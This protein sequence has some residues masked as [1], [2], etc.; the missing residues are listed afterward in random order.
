MEETNIQQNFK[1]LQDSH[2]SMENWIILNNLRP[3][4]NSSSKKSA[5]D[6]IGNSSRLDF[7]SMY[8]Q[9]GK[10]NHSGKLIKL[11][12]NESPPYLTLTTSKT[13]EH[14]MESG[15]EAELLKTVR[16][17]LGFRY[18]IL[19]P[20]DGEW[21]R[22]LP[23]GSWTGLVGMLNRKEADI[24]AG[25]IT[26]TY[27]RHKACGFSIPYDIQKSV[28][29]S[30]VPG[31]K[32]KTYAVLT[33]FTAEVWVLFIILLLIFLCLLYG[34]Q[35]AYHH[36]YQRKTY[37]FGKLFL[38]LLGTICSEG[39]WL[40]PVVQGPTSVLL[41]CLWLLFVLVMQAAYSSTLMS[42]LSFPAYDPP[43]DTLNDLAKFVTEKG[44]KCGC[45][46][47]TIN[48]DSM[49]EL[50]SELEVIAKSLDSDKAN[51]VSSLREGLDKVWKEDFAFLAQK[52]GSIYEAQLMEE[53]NF[54]F[55]GDVLDVELF[56]LAVRIGFSYRKDINTVIRRLSEAGLITKWRNDLTTIN[57]MRF[58]M[59]KGEVS[60]VTPLSLK[61]LKGVVYLLM[62]GL[63]LAAIAFICENL[64]IVSQ[65][66]SSNVLPVEK[67]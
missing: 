18:Q 13:G 36:F 25:C 55:S 30:R 5:S 64:R 2:C 60:V 6:K 11:V 15:P 47:G 39:G 32:S 44:Y 23:N 33:P 20:Q 50:R 8:K 37:K 28:I 31:L 40:T 58:D 53:Q 63:S 1:T 29:I 67:K 59:R 21:G 26:I 10:E 61:E 9:E 7:N 12:V 38:Y 51:F 22:Q 17:K 14:M 16:E 3:Q 34:T 56:S 45:R 57:N 27:Q 66:Y 43:I 62:Y 52:I 24:A 46:K 4:R 65:K 48:C 41:V 54:H 49:L 42:V 35:K 19:K